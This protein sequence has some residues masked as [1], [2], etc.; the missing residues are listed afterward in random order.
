MLV[1][2][3]AQPYVSE[4]TADGELIF[5]AWFAPGYI[6][7]RAY[8]VPWA[9][10]P[11]GAPAVLARR[12]RQGVDIHVSWNGDTGVSD[13]TVLAGTAGHDAVATAA[14]SGFETV[15]GVPRAPSRLRVAAT[16]LGGRVLATSAAVTA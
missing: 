5:D 8:R 6:S 15:I 14:R 11:P 9:A 12:A 16:D 10:Q 13:W 2:W 7:Y 1:G 3:G 4:F